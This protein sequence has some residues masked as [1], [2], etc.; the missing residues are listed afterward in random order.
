M[1][2]SDPGTS[3]AV[4]IGV[5]SYAALPGLPAVENNLT[6]LHAALTNLD[7]WGLP[8]KNCQ[9]VAQPASAGAILNAVI[10]AGRQATDTLIVY[11]A[12]HGLTDPFTDELYLTLPDSEP[13][14]TATGLAYEFLRRSVRDQRVRAT[15]KVVIL[16][17]C[18]SGRAADGVMS[19][20]VAGRTV[21]DGTHVLTASG[22][23]E[24][25]W[26]PP[27]ERHT[28]FTGELV[29][30]IDQGIPY[31]PDPLSMDA[32]YRHVHTE[33]TAKGRPL[34]HQYNRNA[35]GDIAIARNRSASG[36]APALLPTTSPIQFPSRR[37]PPW[38]W[39]ALA[40]VVTLLAGTVA[41]TILDRRSGPVRLSDTLTDCRKAGPVPS[42]ATAAYSCRDWPGGPAVVDV[43]PD[44]RALDAGYATVVGDAGVPSSTGDCGTGEDAEHRY[45]A[46]GTAHGRVL[47]YTRD[48]ATTVVWT[49]DDAHTIARVGAPMTDLRTLRDSWTARTG[50]APA[51]PT[52]DEK[53]L[54]DLPVATGCTRAGIPDLDD[55]PGAIA[56]VTCS[57]T[58][59]AGAQSVTYFRFDSTSKLQATMNAHIPAGKDP[60][61]DGC[62]DG[63]AAKF[64]D[65]RRYDLRG[66]F[67][68]LL[69]CHP[70]PDGNLV[71]EWSVEP[72][73]VAGRAVGTGAADLAAWWR[74]DRGPPIPTVVEAVNL[75][76][77]FPDAAE[78]A[79]LNRIPPQSRQLCMRP[80]GEFRTEH[81]GTYRV[82][83]GA[84]CD[85]RT[86]PPIVF[87][88]QFAD[89]AEMR[90]NYGPP[91]TPAGRC[92]AA[93][94]TASGE[95]AYARGGSTG[96]L[97]CENRD[98][99]LAR[100]WTDERRLIQGFA[101]QGRD[102]R[103][104][105]D[106]WEHDAGPL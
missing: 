39:V 4:L 74:V 77:K 55:F 68:G 9:V 69:L 22:A 106:W 105:T 90:Q 6:D 7:I 8:P 48:D 75:R 103:A 50:P 101:F 25:A 102:A 72:L 86:G 20:A 63:K 96:R 98:G 66:V 34:P 24:T 56:A 36:P 16:D 93:P 97:R 45:P 62:Q 71:L 76:D 32:V 41:A 13:E 42:G 47:C 27:G 37:K 54:I 65:G 44:R 64:T 1:E 31:G 10:E 28:A 81:V 84:V 94:T 57:G 100:I 92:T 78:T 80:S 17:C 52:P 70:A 83:A 91:G 29:R 99:Y 87:Y 51:F 15:R 61:G 30:V 38:R 3:R 95:S 60:A 53:K 49:D 14:L 88:Y 79:L 40:A 89:R 67:L 35:G 21:T 2:L 104:M 46:T 11:Y 33:L 73:L 82:T 59:G 19:A 43:Y 23:T 85:P 58:G 26:S 18:Y 12:G 5:H